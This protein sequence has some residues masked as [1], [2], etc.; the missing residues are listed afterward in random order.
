[1]SIKNL[2]MTLK[3]V[4]ALL[5]SAMIAVSASASAADQPVILIIDQ[6]KVMATSKA[7]VSINGQMAN[8]EE[9]ANKFLAD[10]QQRILKEAEELKQKK[11]NMEEAKFVE[12]AKRLN[13][14][15]SNMPS[16]QQIKK[17]E[18]ALTQQKSYAAVLKALDPI[19][20]E[21]VE[22]K[23]ATLLL[24]RSAVMF[25]AD[26]TDVTDEVI[27]KLNASMA[28]YTVEPVVLIKKKEK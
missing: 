24:D 13:E 4:F 3:G 14:A 17:Q 5:V 1:M 23:K 11:A 2:N 21:V 7:G 26:S 22:Q 16:L 10:E 19:L 20:K 28:T 8:L 12:Q 27:K 25:A 6:A 18:I 9:A 15:Q